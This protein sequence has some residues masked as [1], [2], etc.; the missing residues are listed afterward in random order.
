MCFVKYKKLCMHNMIFTV[1]YSTHIYIIRLIYIIHTHSI[2]RFII[3]YTLL[4]LISGPIY[5]VNIISIVLFEGVIVTIYHLYMCFWYFFSCKKCKVL[6]SGHFYSYKLSRCRA[7]SFSFVLANQNKEIT[8]ST[9]QRRRP[10]PVMFWQPA[11]SRY[12]C[13]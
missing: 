10:A 12:K 7:A 3:T 1:L 4:C 13:I 11:Q 2:F 8:K 9:N 6:N 5:L